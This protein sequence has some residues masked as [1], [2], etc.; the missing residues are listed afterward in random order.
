MR[1]FFFGRSNAKGFTLLEVLIS[2]ALMGIVAALGFAILIKGAQYLRVNQSAIDAQKDGL[3]LLTQLH[4]DLQTTDQQ[5][6]LSTPQGAVFP[7]PYK[8][9]GTT[10]FDPVTQKLMWQRWVCYAYDTATLKVTRH[11][12]PISPADAT[13]GAPPAPAAFLP[14]AGSKLLASEVSVFRV[15]QVTV[16]P[17]LWQID[18][19]VGDMNDSSRYGV[20]LQSKVSPR[21]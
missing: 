16:T 8:D 3:L 18:V 14:Q 7:S 21:N 19:T 10:E 12:M 17:P 5:L 6:L 4:G 11:E 15:T 13:P 1:R 20:E 2:A 9:N